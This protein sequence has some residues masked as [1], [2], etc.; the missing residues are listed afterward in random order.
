V[1]GGPDDRCGWDRFR[2]SILSMRTDEREEERVSERRQKPMRGFVDVGD[3]GVVVLV[4]VW[5]RL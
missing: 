3:V 2:S 4:P 5:L 1:R